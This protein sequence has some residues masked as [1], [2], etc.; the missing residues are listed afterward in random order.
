MTTTVSEAT[1]LK[2]LRERIGNDAFNRLVVRLSWD[3]TF[4]ADTTTLA[5]SQAMCP[6]RQ[7][8]WQGLE[9]FFRVLKFLRRKALAL[10]LQPEQ[11]PRFDHRGLS[12]QFSPLRKCGLELD[13]GRAGDAE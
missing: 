4:R 11:M 9:T 13:T 1:E 10:F 12:Q 8:R 6:S 3:N 5:R 2:E 7:Y